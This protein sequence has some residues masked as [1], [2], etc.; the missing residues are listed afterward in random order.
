MKMFTNINCLFTDSSGGE[1]EE[2]TGETKDITYKIH[3]PLATYSQNH[4]VHIN[5]DDRQ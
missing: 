5:R 3:F 1:T 4:T 2:E